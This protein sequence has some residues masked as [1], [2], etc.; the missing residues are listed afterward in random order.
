MTFNLR[1]TATDYQSGTEFHAE[2]ALN[3]HFPFGLAAGVGGYF[4]QQLTGD[5]GPGAVLGS[6]RGR[7]AAVGP[8]LSYTFKVDTQQV[9]ISG[10]W[11]HEFDTKR[12]VRG[13]SI[14]ASLSFPL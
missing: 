12:R 8:L 14:F 9:T 10:R 2:G 5:T 4:Y 6:F 1:N 7:V 3:Q 11:F 13:D